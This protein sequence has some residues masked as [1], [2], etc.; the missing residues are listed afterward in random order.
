[1]WDLGFGVW[2]YTRWV[3]LNNKQKPKGA[4][5]FGWWLSAFLVTNVPTHPVQEVPRMWI[6]YSMQRDRF[7]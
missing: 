3:D 2:A 4:V 7:A 6:M 5:L 1:M